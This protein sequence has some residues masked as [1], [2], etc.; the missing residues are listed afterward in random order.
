MEELEKYQLQE[1]SNNEIKMRMAIINL[2]KNYTTIEYQ[3][4]KD[5]IFIILTKEKREMERE[6]TH[7]NNSKNK[8][9]YLGG[10]Y[11]I[12]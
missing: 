2:K 4:T 6:V 3:E 8:K 12:N 9:K 5:E 7:R 11:K 1:D 10:I